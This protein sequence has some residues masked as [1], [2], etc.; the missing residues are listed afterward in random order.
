MDGDTEEWKRKS[1]VALLSLMSPFQIFTFLVRKVNLW[2]MLV[3]A[4]DIFVN[5]CVT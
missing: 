4:Y 2:V 1:E 5:G 3:T